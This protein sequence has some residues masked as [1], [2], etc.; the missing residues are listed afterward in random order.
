M[1][2]AQMS[3]FLVEKTTEDL[4]NLVP[5]LHFPRSNH[6]LLETTVL[7]RTIISAS[8]H[9]QNVLV[10]SPKCCWQC[11]LCNLS[12]YH[13]H[14]WC[15]TIPKWIRKVQILTRQNFFVHK[16]FIPFVKTVREIVAKAGKKIV[17]IVFIGCNFFHVEKS[18]HILYVLC[19]VCVKWSK[20]LCR[21][22]IER[23]CNQ[24]K[25]FTKSVSN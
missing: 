2:S 5:G 12:T 20:T 24:K 14:V 23:W 16:L 15:L 17:Q 8:H 7:G 18:N 4:P 11:C 1:C 9:V 6:C 19:S 25:P 22:M 3:L 13:S 10:I 21:K